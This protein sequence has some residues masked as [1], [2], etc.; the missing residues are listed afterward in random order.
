MG[1]GSAPP[2]FSP[3]EPQQEG[4]WTSGARANIGSPVDNGATIDVPVSGVTDGKPYI[5]VFGIVGNSQAKTDYVTPQARNSGGSLTDSNMAYRHSWNSSEH[6]FKFF[7]P[8]GTTT[9]RFTKFGLFNG[10]ILPFSLS[11]IVQS[12]LYPTPSAKMHEFNS[13]D[14]G[15]SGTPVVLTLH[16]WTQF[17]ASL[18]PASPTTTQAGPLHIGSE[19]QNTGSDTVIT[20]G[21]PGNFAKTNHGFYDLITGTYSRTSPSTTLTVTTASAHG[22]STGDFVYIAFTSGGGVSGSFSITVTGATT[23]TVTTVASTTVSGNASSYFQNTFQISVFP[24]YAPNLALPTPIGAIPTSYYVK[25][26]DKDNYNVSTTDPGKTNA[27]TAIDVTVAGGSPTNTYKAVQV[28]TSYSMTDTVTYDVQEYVDLTAHSGMSMR[29]G[30]QEYQH[31]QLNAT[32]TQV[33]SGKRGANGA[34]A[35]EFPIQGNV[36]IEGRYANSGL[37]SHY[38]RF[39]FPAVAGSVTETDGTPA[40]FAYSGAT[41]FGP[42]NNGLPATLTGDATPYYVYNNVTAD[43][44]NNTSG[45]FNL[46]TTQPTPTLI[47][48]SSLG[49][50]VHTLNI[51][52]TSN[53]GPISFEGNPNAPT[54]QALVAGMDF[55]KV[56]DAAVDSKHPN[57]TIVSC[58][59]ENIPGFMPARGFMTHSYPVGNGNTRFLQSE[60]PDVHAID[61]YGYGFKIEDL[62]CFTPLFQAVCGEELIVSYDQAIARSYLGVTTPTGVTAA[63][64]PIT[65]MPPASLTPEVYSP[66]LA[67][68]A[69]YQIGAGAQVEISLVKSGPFP[70]TMRQNFTLAQLGCAASSTLKVSFSYWDGIADDWSAWTDVDGVAGFSTLTLGGSLGSELSTLLANATTMTGMTPAASVYTVPGDPAGNGFDK[71]AGAGTSL[72]PTVDVSPANKD[73]LCTGIL[74]GMP[75]GNNLKIQFVNGAG[76]THQTNAFPANVAVAASGTFQDQVTV[77]NNTREQVTP[78]ASG[79]TWTGGKF[80][81]KPINRRGTA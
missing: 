54:N 48:A 20:T 31:P 2:S 12:A 16:N 13:Y 73:Y 8:V 63:N 27:G 66:V 70:S 76:G 33:K 79:T 29:G 67:W 7:A 53:A 56:G 38:G 64:V 42:M 80:S 4:F 30:Y 28:G 61:G 17:A 21:T 18:A 3:P 35:T 71:A 77:L 69:R 49:N 58:V 74:N 52:A 50:G 60:S 11:R 10:T 26:V 23:Y 62:G 37:A 25:L 78:S 40:S 24:T 5:F 36:I 19:I 43:P 34:S 44:N 46:S 45:T 1:G 22:R 15:A 75:T 51:A 68:R 59:I 81:A 65:R 14:S 55:A 72:R 47:T 6:T 57:L 32:W 41:N 9:I 39:Q